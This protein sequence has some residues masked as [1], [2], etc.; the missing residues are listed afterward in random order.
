MRLARRDVQD[1]ATLACQAICA[2]IVPERH[3]FRLCRRFA[4]L[5]MRWHKDRSRRSCARIEAACRGQAMPLDPVEVE[6]ERIAGRYYERLIIFGACRLGGWTPRVELHGRERL[7]QA[8]AGGR[9]AILWVSDFSASALVAK[10]GLHS[11]GIAITHLSRPTH[12]FSRTAFGIRFLN[13]LRS[14]VEGR[15]LQD[16]I[17]IESDDQARDAMR[18][19][20]STLQENGVV[21]ITVG[22]WARRTQLVPLLSGRITYATGPV[23]LARVSGAPLL[24]VFTVRDEDETFH[25]HIGPA[26]EV[27]VTDDQKEYERTL[28]RYVEQLEPFLR[29]YAGQWRTWTRV[30]PAEAWSVEE[31]LGRRARPAHGTAAMD[32]VADG[33]GGERQ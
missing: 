14:R 25:V 4:R 18:R 2:W 33:Q 28:R 31:S 10:I 20:R 8:L 5:E 32:A 9:G 1:V 23:H 30:Q 19:L 22:A 21:S 12:G 15:Y 24:P 26:L 3:W 29:R 11:A 13:P 7:D 27:P 6:A 16:R 17:V